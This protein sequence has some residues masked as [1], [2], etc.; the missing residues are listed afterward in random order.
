[1][2][3]KLDL[4]TQAQIHDVFHISQLKKCQGPV[5]TAGMLPHCDGDGLIQAEPV[6]ILDRRLGK[7]GNSA[8]VFVLVQWSNST[9]ADATWEPIDEIQNRFPS[10]NVLA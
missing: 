4:P 10:F 8:A 1:M 9:P 6:A 7:V 3:Y 5:T 2:A